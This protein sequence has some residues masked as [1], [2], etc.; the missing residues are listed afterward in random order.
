MRKIFFLLIIAVLISG[1]AMIG[2]HARGGRTKIDYFAEQQLSFVNY[3]KN[4]YPAHDKNYPIDLYFED[5]P[6]KPYEVIGEII[7]FFTH[8]N[9]LRALLEARARQVGAD[10]VIDI[11][12][13]LGTITNTGITQRSVSDS[14]GNIVGTMP[15]ATTSSQKV[16]NIKAKVINYKQ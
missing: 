15:V 4:I 2:D 7:G 1:C 3:S 5:K 11:Q 16:V 6:Q 9:D 14:V 10:A 8:D 13:S 12:T